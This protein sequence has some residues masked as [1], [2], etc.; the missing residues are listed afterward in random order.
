MLLAQSRGHA[1]SVFYVSVIVTRVFR[2]T[3]D[4]DIQT[5]LNKKYKNLKILLINITYKK[6]KKIAFL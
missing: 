2:R 3:G 4:F 1:F 5:Q 6:M